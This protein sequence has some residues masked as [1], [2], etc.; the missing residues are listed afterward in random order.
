MFLMH[1]LPVMVGAYNLSIC[2]AS[3]RAPYIE[4]LSYHYNYMDVLSST[5]ALCFSVTPCHYMN[6]KL[7]SLVIQVRSIV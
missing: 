1:A 5:K 7:L 6:C 3:I 2:I 4:I